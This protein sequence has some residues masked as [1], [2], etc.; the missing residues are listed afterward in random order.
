MQIPWSFPIGLLGVNMLYVCAVLFII[1]LGVEGRVKPLEVMIMCFITGTI[2]AISGFYY[3]L[4]LGDVASM[5]GSFLFGFTYY[6]Y[7]FDILGRA[8]NYKGLGHY[9]L[10]VVFATWPYIYFN[11]IGGWYLVAFFWVLWM[12]LWFNY[13]LFSGL[14]KVGPKITAWNTYL[15]AVING[16]VALGFIFGYFTPMGIP[17]P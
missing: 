2:N 6:F 13:Y 17:L 7:A 1:G 8:E 12:Q 9:A 5:A 10:F 16:I 3:G 11:I 4:I 15:V 14:G